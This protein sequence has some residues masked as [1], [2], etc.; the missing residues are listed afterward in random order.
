MRSPQPRYRLFCFA[1]PLFLRYQG[2][3]TLVVID[4]KCLDRKFP[5]A[6]CAQRVIPASETR[7]KPIKAKQ[8]TNKLRVTLIS[9]N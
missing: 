2:I 1:R 9:L 6:L 4:Q 3:D 7:F 8:V 5:D